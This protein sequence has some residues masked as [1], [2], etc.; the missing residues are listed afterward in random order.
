MNKKFGDIPASL[1]QSL[2]T[3][4][5]VFCIFLVTGYLDDTLFVTSI[6]AS[7]FIAFSHPRTQAVKIRCLPGG[8]AFAAFWGSICGLAGRANTDGDTKDMLVYCMT[9]VFLTA[10]C[11]AFFKLEHPPS[12]AL[13]ISITYSK[14]P[15][16]LAGVALVC[17]LV[18][19]ACRKIMLLFQD[20]K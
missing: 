3:A 13:A 1:L 8:Y 16:A 9:A 19:S 2:C 11:M 14:R 6:G 4:G 7:A 18:L 20:K 10:L 17:I 15:L 12:V 5:F